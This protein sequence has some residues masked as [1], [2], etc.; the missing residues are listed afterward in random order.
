ML[1]SWRM[2]KYESRSVAELLT[3]LFDGQPHLLAAQ[4]ETWLESS[5]RFSA[6]V[7]TF[8]DKIRKKLRVTQDPETLQDLRLEL[9]TA[10]LLLQE[11]TLSV[12]Y[13]PEQSKQVRSPDF[14]VTYT[15]SLTFMV[16][17]T[18][19]RGAPPLENGLLSENERLADAICSKLGQFLP[20]RGNVLV[21]RI[22]S[23][24]M[25][26]NDLQSTMLRIQQRAERNDSAFW[27]RYGFQDRADFFRHYGRLSEILVRN[28][29]LTSVESVI[30]WV[31]SRAKHPLPSKV[32]TSLYR[33]HTGKA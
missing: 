24:H 3:Y 29:E 25:T 30:T 13:E 19:L 32:R 14:A 31:N 11:K 5:R 21:V 7:T 4:M 22:E 33:S 10:Y 18:R 16:E 17:V 6:F 23:S 12:A 26:Q 27:Q 9:E 2:R 20:Q 8:R 15:T 1:N 28:S